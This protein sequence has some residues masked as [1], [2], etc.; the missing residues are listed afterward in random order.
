M[1]Y[2][3][4]DE[5]EAVS[6][7]AP[8]GGVTVD[9]PVLIGSLFGVPAVTAAEAATFNLLTHGV[10]DALPKTTGTAWTAGQKLYWNDST[11]KFTTVA[12]D[13]DVGA[14]A[15]DAAGSSATTGAVRLSGNCR[16]ALADLKGEDGAIMKSGT[17]TIA[18]GATTAAVTFTTAFPAGTTYRVFLSFA[19]NP[20]ATAKVYPASVAVT[21]FTITANADPANA[22][23]CPVNWMVRAY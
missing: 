6:C 4:R 21:G 17:A 1:T 13:I 3:Y 8:S 12:T 22:A 7:I 18:N 11:H 15:V 5:G 10:W 14:H 2:S 20:Q 16:S 19:G 9:V 23:G